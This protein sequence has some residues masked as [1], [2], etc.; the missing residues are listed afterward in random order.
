MGAFRRKWPGLSYGRGE[1]W[2]YVG[3]TDEPAFENSWDNAGVDQ[4]ALA[5]RI[6]E[7]GAVDIEGVLDGS[8]AT[9]TTVFT[10][11]EG[12]RPTNKTPGSVVYVNDGTAARLFV[13]AGGAVSIEGPVGSFPYADTIHI[14]GQFYLEPPVTAP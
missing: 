5:F 14:S 7:G 11:P 3:D 6:R 12:Y 8:A 2:H 13:S 4:A 9:L 1:A 10:L